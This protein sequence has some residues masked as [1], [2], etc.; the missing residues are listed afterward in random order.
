MRLHQ[1]YEVILQSFVQAQQDGRLDNVPLRLGHLTKKVNLKIPL[2]FI[3]GDVQG[4]DNICARSAYYG[5]TAR[6]IS[7]TCDATPD[8]LGATD[9]DCCHRLE[10]EDV[11]QL[12]EDQDFD[13]L[14]S[15]MQL[16][17]WNAFFPIE[18]G[19]PYGIFTAACPPE[20]LHALE[21]GLIKDVLNEI[22]RTILKPTFCARFDSVIQQWSRLPRQKYLR[23]TTTEDS[24]RLLFHNGIT[25]VTETT[26]MEKV[27]MLFATCIAMLTFDGH[28]IM[29]TKCHPDTSNFP[30]QTKRD[31]YLDILE[32][33]ELLLC[34]WAWFKNPH[35]GPGPTMK[36]MIL[37][38]LLFQS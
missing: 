30:N 31:V 16:P 5:T 13:I 9:V 1:C 29:E 11:R 26:A 7:R 6:R 33:C 28:C 15:M 36:P 37:Q 12:V 10:M 2:F 23:S 8:M 32:T 25:R 22:F 20:G 24:L 38:S 27:G 34:Y 21:N 4:G 3:I 19:H 35:F 17:H 18:Y 14:H